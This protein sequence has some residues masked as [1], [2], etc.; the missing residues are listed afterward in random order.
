MA[1]SV[2]S[3]IICMDHLN[4]EREVNLVEELG[5]DYLHVDMMD[6]DFVPRYGIYPEIVERI[7]EISLMKMD[8]HLMLNNIDLALEHIKDVKNV[9]YVSFHIG[10]NENNSLRIVDKIHSLDKKAGVVFNLSTDINK[11][12]DL[13]EEDEID[14]IMLMGIHPG[15]LKQT[16]RP[17][18]VL[19]KLKQVRKLLEGKKC[20]NFIQIDGGVSF[21]SIPEMVA[22]GANNLICGSSTLYRGVNPLN[23]WKMNKV[24]IAQNFNKIKML[25]DT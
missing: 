13:I 19:K 1:C 11:L 4:F 21:D 2:G 24:K 3:S 25:I 8:V 20:A 9:E 12:Y 23:D 5:V 22:T 10:E 6:G 7:A 16:S 18:L 15:V 14:S 17:N